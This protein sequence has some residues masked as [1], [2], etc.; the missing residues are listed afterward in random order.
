MAFKVD[1]IDHVEVF[2]RDI[3]AAAQWYAK[4]LGL[5]EV[6]RWDPEPVMIAA[7]NTKL[8]L[9]RADPAAPSNPDDK[10]R[11]PRWRRVA[12]LTT[13]EGFIEAQEH[14]RQ[15]GVTFSG[16]IDHDSAESI[17]FRDP[18]DNPLEITWYR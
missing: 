7:V 11:S 15:C 10:S 9:F 8:A 6:G 13:A 3:E 18:D 2:V 14:L 17:Y 5:K 1:Q 4:V 16:P 12:W